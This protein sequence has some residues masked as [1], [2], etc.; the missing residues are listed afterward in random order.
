MSKEEG[1]NGWTNYPTWCVNLWF[2]NEESLYHLAQEMAEQAYKDAEA[3]GALTRDEIAS[4][5]LADEIKHWVEEQAGESL[6]DASMLTDL[7]GWAI[8][9]ANYYEIAEHWIADAKEEFANG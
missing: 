1:Y 8:G 3:D 2:Q 5:E 4:I 7:M 9:S 6:N